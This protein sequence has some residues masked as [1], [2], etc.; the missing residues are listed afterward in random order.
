MGRKR[1]HTGRGA[2][3]KP[4]DRSHW[5]D[6]DIGGKMILNEM[7][8]KWDGVIFTGILWLRIGTR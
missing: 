4:E 2:V 5:E 6:L 1:V 7:L 8:E 3:G